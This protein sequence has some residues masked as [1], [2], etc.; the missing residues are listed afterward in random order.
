[1][2]LELKTLPQI[3]KTLGYHTAAFTAAY[4][5]RS[6][7][8]GLGT[9]FDLY[10]DSLNAHA[11]FLS[12][13]EMEPLAFYRFVERL[14]GNQIAAPTVNKRVRSWLASRPPEPFFVWVHYFDP[15]GPFAP[16][17]EYRKLYSPVDDS[18]D[19]RKLAL[20]A[21]EVTYTDE[22][23]RLLLED[24]RA[25]ELLEDALVVLTSDHGE[26]FGE[27]HPHVDRGH[28]RYLYDSVL[29]V[30]LIFWYPSQLSGDIVVDAQV[31]SIDIAPTLLDLIGAAIPDSFQGRSLRPLLEGKGSVASRLAFSE[32]SSFVKSRWYSIR[33]REAKLL[34]NPTDGEEQFFDL[35]S[36]PLERVNLID[37]KPRLLEEYRSQL[38]G[39]LQ[40][41]GDEATLEDL[42]PETIRQLRA[43]GYLDGEEDGSP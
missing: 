26:A 11:S 37:Q 25:A 28:G 30:P 32:T 22:Q 12:S 14:S 18:V 36:D 15:H 8:T 24:F 7:V 4:T 1:M 20:Y 9:S 40:S 31:E 13:D 33:S 43:L 39:T 29:R 10:V 21:A 2:R 27:P 23:L 34:V 41:R 16:S 6:N 19:S 42:S 35:R 17:E 38:S 3:L 5:T